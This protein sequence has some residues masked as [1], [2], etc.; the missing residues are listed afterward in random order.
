MI[1]LYSFVFI[2]YWVCLHLVMYMYGTGMYNVWASGVALT[3]ETGGSQSPWT[4]PK[5]QKVG[6]FSGHRK[7]REHGNV[8]PRKNSKMAE[9]FLDDFTSCHWSVKKCTFSHLI[10]FYTWNAEI[11]HEKGC[12]LFKKLKTILNRIRKHA[13]FG[14]K[15][16]DFC[17]CSQIWK[18]ISMAWLF[19]KILRS[20]ATLTDK[21][22]IFHFLS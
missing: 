2:Q 3:F 1:W 17:A 15:I 20:S 4:P 5:L 22:K 16:L 10:S 12:F 6:L 18:I 7:V 19:L 21:S 14:R 13:L 8:G 11:K 9:N